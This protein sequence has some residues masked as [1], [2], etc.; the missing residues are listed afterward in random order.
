MAET[1]KGSRSMTSWRPPATACGTSRRFRPRSSTDAGGRRVEDAGQPDRIGRVVGDLEEG[2]RGIA[3]GPHRNPVVL[4]IAADQDRLG[5]P[6]RQGAKH[7]GEP[8]NSL[9]VTGD[10]RHR[11]D[12]PVG[13]DRG[14]GVAQRLVGGNAV[15]QRQRGERQGRRRAVPSRRGLPLPGSEPGTRHRRRSS[16]AGTEAKPGPVER[17]A[18]SGS[19]VRNMPR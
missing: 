7:G 17:S 8:A 2:L 6:G 14:Q 13:I 19:I 5:R 3:Q 11:Q 9:L 10:G 15:T 18:V 16:P 1:P 4:L 12:D